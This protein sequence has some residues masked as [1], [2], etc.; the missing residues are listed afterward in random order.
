MRRGVVPNRDLM[1]AADAAR[2]LGLSADM[3]RLLA[4]DGRLRV[5]VKSVRGV[6]LFRREDVEALAAER[7]GVRHHN[8]LVQFYE[9]EDFLWGVV[10]EFVRDG[11]NGG[12][13][14]VVV[15][16]APHR[17]ALC[18]RLAADGV[19]VD[20]A[21]AS[22]QLALLDARETLAS[23]M[24]D[25]SLDAEKF[26]QNAGGLIAE[27]V[28][29]SRAR[30]RA[31]GEMVN[32]LW[33]DGRPDAACRLEALWN[34]LAAVHPFSLLCGY[35]MDSFRT[36]D[37]SDPFQQVC[38]LHT[39]VAPSEGYGDDADPHLRDRRI[40]LLHQRSRALDVEIERRRR[41]EDEVRELRAELQRLKAGP[42]A[43]A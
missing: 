15:A 5:A 41:V 35:A 36:G 42:S 17:Q 24:V 38:E 30:I 34:D 4:R 37:D 27:R 26:Q 1:T 16:T 18:A 11:L 29:R 7:A 32:L 10:A 13:P 6:R 25:G 3:V 9:D 43:T 39:H 31:Y 28:G 12:A 20:D 21:V 40:A 2:I 14:I 8:H 22:G 23:L 33:E 19:R